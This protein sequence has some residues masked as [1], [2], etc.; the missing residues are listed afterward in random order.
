MQA[1]PPS[2][3][4]GVLGAAR[5]VPAALI[6][7]AASLPGIEVTA[8]AAR[9]PDRAQAFAA[10][11]GIP[12]VHASYADLV[13]DPALDAVYIPLPNSLHCEWTLAALAAGKHVLCEKP[14][15]ANTQEAERMAQAASQAGRILMEAFHYRYH[16]L[17]ARVQAIVASGELGAVHAIA[18]SMCIP[19]LRP[20][21]IR[22]RYDL[23]GGATMDAGC[24]A[25]HMA[26][27]L[28]GSEPHVVSAH[29]LLRS[30]QLDR[31]MNARLDF[32][33]GISGRIICSLLSRT[34]LRI[35]AVVIGERGVLRVINPVLPHHFHLIHVHPV[36]A[37]RWERVP[38]H[39][40]YTYQLR[41]FADAVGGGRAP[42]TDPSD[43][44]ANMRVIDDIYTAAGLCRRGV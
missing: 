22:Y 1:K 40:T 33:K 37:G 25:I 27:T 38:G 19:L 7:P 21:D 34:L 11:H 31:A 28:A 6:S 20:R 8:I 42:L 30:P 5:I 14:I 18:T 44:V 32:A 36:D 24:Y 12:V 41:A 9:R 2:L 29:A 10:Q 43:A 26:R 39:S 17:M 35:E 23:A 15:A 16:P 3:R 4:I 13:H